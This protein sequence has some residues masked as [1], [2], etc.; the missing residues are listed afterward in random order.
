M[1]YS[2]QIIYTLP[3]SA[4]KVIKEYRELPLGKHKVVC[5]YIINPKTQRAGLRVLIGKG[6]PGEIAR[7]TQVVS[8][9]KGVDLNKMTT[10]EIRKFMQDR[11]IGIDC[12]GFIVHIVNF[13]LKKQGKQALVNYLVFPENSFYHRLKRLLRPVEQIGAQLMTNLDNC[14]EITDLNQVRPGD[15]IRSKGIRKNAHHISL[16]SK[17]V[18]E[19]NKVKEIEYI[20]SQRY[21]E[22]DNG[23]RT[24]TIKTKSLKKPLIEQEWT[25]ELDGRNWTKEGYENQIEDNGIR[26]LKRVSLNFQTIETT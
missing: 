7:E 8:Q 17:V 2:M 16:V 4:Q 15:F 20:H 13:W 11:R 10:A 21:Y 1:T 22:D 12:S 9:V 3:E 18:T 26:R 24:G 5:P 19:D 25:E 23:I 6:D 14:E